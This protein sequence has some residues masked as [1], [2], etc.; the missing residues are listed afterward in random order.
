MSS[1]DNGNSNITV[2]G[3]I[4]A[5]WQ[6]DIKDRNVKTTNDPE[7]IEYATPTDEEMGDTNFDFLP[8]DVDES[9]L[10]ELQ[11]EILATAFMRNPDSLA[12][13]ARMVGCSGPAVGSTLGTYAPDRKDEI[14]MSP[15]EKAEMN[16]QEMATEDDTAT[17]AVD[18]DAEFTTDT[19]AMRVDD[20]IQQCKTLEAV[21]PDDAVG[22]AVR[23][24]RATLEGGSE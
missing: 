4:D 24:I 17:N 2:E 7:S 3:G 13:L 12:H 16:F 9:D 21:H 23:E 19:T 15:E 1:K 5:S 22:R 14:T 8:S 11:Q 18:P 10:T 20:A 6:S